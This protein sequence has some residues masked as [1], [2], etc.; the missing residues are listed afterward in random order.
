MKVQQFYNKNQFIIYGDGLT[1]FQSYNSTIAII[2]DKTLTFGKNWD[3]SN[4]TRKHLYLFLR[5]YDYYLN[6]DIYNK[7]QEAL[8]TKNIRKALQN[9][10]DNKVIAYD[11]TL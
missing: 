5:D 9:L 11:D 1:I 2:K 3:Y 6:D 7:I 4:T 8:Y 10:I